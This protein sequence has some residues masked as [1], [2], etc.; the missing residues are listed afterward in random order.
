MRRNEVLA[1]PTVWWPR[2]LAPKVLGLDMYRGA[3]RLRCKPKVSPLPRPADAR[4]ARCGCSRLHLKSGGTLHRKT[5]QKITRR[6]GMV[7]PLATHHSYD[8][9]RTEEMEIL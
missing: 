2:E 1:A 4:V 3:G 5:G 7:N 8:A 6:L 9:E